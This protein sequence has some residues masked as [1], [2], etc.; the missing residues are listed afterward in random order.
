M[1]VAKLIVFKNYCSPVGW[2]VRRFSAATSRV[3]SH[4][5]RLQP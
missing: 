4:R 3:R 5:S 1:E 2:V